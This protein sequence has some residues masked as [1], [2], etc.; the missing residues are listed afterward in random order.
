[1]LGGCVPSRESKW[2]GIHFLAE[3]HHSVKK[4]KK[5]TR[6]PLA[7]R[8]CSCEKD[9]RDAEQS[10]ASKH[11]ASTASSVSTVP[12]GE[13]GGGDKFSKD[14]SLQEPHHGSSSP[15]GPRKDATNIVTALSSAKPKSIYRRQLPCP[16]AL[17]SLDSER[18][19][20]LFIKGLQG[21]TMTCYFSLAQNFITQDEPSFCGISTLV[22]T[23]NTLDIDSGRIWKGPWRWFHES[24][25]NCCDSL[26]D[27]KKRGISIPSWLCLAECNG[28]DIVEYS[29]GGGESL[30][31]FRQ[32]VL[33]CTR[34]PSKERVLVVSYSRKFFGQTGDGHFSPIGGMCEEEDAVLILDVARFKYPAHWVKLEDLWKA[35][36]LLDPDTGNPRGCMVL[37]P[38]VMP[39][40]IVFTIKTS[41]D[42]WDEFRRFMHE[43]GDFFSQ[44]DGLEQ[45]LS[46][47]SSVRGEECCWSGQNADLSPEEQVL[48]CFFSQMP[49]T[50]ADSVGLL[51]GDFQDL[52]FIPVDHKAAMDKLSKD[53]EN[54]EVFKLV[55]QVLKSLGRENACNMLPTALV[56]AFP[57]P[58]EAKTSSMQ[59]FRKLQDLSDCSST[60]Q[61]EIESL[62]NQFIKFMAPTKRSYKLCHACGPERNCC[63][64]K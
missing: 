13:A 52:P 30:D 7:M 15:G 8:K 18:G 38:A 42:A 63:S 33:E 14:T 29:P 43:L 26:E 61:D 35:M 36:K 39:G 27:I 17:A 11:P 16:P 58:L 21:G 47:K 3:I 40:T 34:A 53:L 64:Q 49:K 19:Q 28:A 25:L 31:R 1:V 5:R 20:E 6:M 24:M 50:V 62:H 2:M 41:P 45:W 23:L 12:R 32:L 56:L 22:M 54:L 37:E 59:T 4:L 46:C 48:M 44:E 60:T 9:E 55:E 51:R 10:K 57:T